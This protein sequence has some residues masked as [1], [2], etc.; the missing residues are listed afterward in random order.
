[1]ERI[2]RKQFIVQ[3]FGALG[4]TIGIVLLAIWADEAKRQGA[5]IA[6]FIIYMVI[7]ARATAARLHD[8]GWSGWWMLTIL[9]VPLLFVLRGTSGHNRYGP[10]PRQS[11]MS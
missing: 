1:M 9:P 2:G 4:L 11:P 6:G 5:G 10:D 8:L 7:A 3:L